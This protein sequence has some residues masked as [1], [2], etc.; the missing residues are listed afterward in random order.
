MKKHIFVISVAML[1][2]C[3]SLLHYKGYDRK[4]IRKIYHIFQNKNVTVDNT[5]NT[6]YLTLFNDKNNLHLLSA[7]KLGIKQPLKNRMDADSVIGNLVRIKS[8]KYYTIDKLTHSMPYLTE[9]AATL[10]E[11]IGKNFSDSLKRKGLKSNKII[12]TSVLRTQEDIKKIQ[13]SGNPNAHKN[14]AHCYGTTFDITY[15][16]YARH[17]TN[18]RTLK[19][20]LGEVLWEL[21]KQNKCYVKYEVRQHC[22]HITTRE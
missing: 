10:L 15:V 4:I 1:V 5:D 6:D 20:V 18:P 21:K 11:T 19:K 8:N 22:F 16:R 9:G 12:V 7:R 3:V 13:N 2:T 17:N 14:S